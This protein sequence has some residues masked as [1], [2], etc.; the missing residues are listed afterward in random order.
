VTNEQAIM[1]AHPDEWTARTFLEHASLLRCLAAG[2]VTQLDAQIGD[3]L[4]VALIGNFTIRSGAE[5]VLEPPVDGGI[6]KRDW[7]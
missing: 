4:V 5:T 7:S 3:H 2:R 1:P 6:G